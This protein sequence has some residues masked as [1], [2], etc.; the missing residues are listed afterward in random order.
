MNFTGNV[1]QPWRHKTNANVRSRSPIP[2]CTLAERIV[3]CFALVNYT[4]VLL[5]WSG[6][7]RYEITKGLKV[8]GAAGDRGE[9]EMGLVVV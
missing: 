1:L 4:F 5:L 3:V 2:N 9:G 6:S 8:G 7:G